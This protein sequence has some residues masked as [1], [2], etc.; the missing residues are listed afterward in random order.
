MH[1]YSDVVSDVVLFSLCDQATQREICYRLRSVFCAPGSAVLDAGCRPDAI[2]LVRFGVV[3]GSPSSLLGR[4]PLSA[5]PLRL[6]CSL[7]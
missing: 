1:L 5:L 7:E 4:L 6:P 2:Y 3:Q